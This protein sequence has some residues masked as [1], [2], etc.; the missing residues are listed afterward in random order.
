MQQKAPEDNTTGPG[1]PDIEIASSPL[2][3]KEHGMDPPPC[4]GKDVFALHTVL[5]RYVLWLSSPSA[6]ISHFWLGQRATVPSVSDQATQRTLRCSIPSSSHLQLFMMS[7]LKISQVPLG[8]ERHQSP[9]A[10]CQAP[11]QD[12]AHRTP[13]VDDRP[14][15]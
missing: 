14:S 12:L 13:R 11:A 15:R 9:C 10:W 8:R 3:Y 2:A 5:L 1:A 7:L 6:K 4:L